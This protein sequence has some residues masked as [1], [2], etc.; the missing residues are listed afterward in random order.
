[1]P[2]LLFSP[3]VSTSSCAFVK[4]YRLL[5]EEHEERIIMIIVWHVGSTRQAFWRR[6]GIEGS[7]TPAE[8][9]GPVP[10]EFAGAAVQGT[11][12]PIVVTCTAGRLA[13]Q[14]PVAVACI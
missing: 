2:R 11:G 7:L 10:E 8:C 12:R 6:Q 5:F 14:R 13:R 3:T 1:M 9:T 4:Q